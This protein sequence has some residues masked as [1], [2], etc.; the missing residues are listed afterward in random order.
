MTSVSVPS[1]Y[2]QESSSLMIK[3]DGNSDILSRELV[4]A[5]RKQILDSAGKGTKDTEK[6]SKTYSE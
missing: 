1:E 4:P 2:Q 5:Q 3:E 6:D